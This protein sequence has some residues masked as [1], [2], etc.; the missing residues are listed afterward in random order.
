MVIAAFWGIIAGSALLIGAVTGIYSKIS[1]R[2]TGLIM[3]FGTGALIAAASFELLSEALKESSI[4]NVALFFI[5]GALIFTIGDFAV[6][7]FGG[8]ERKRSKEG[9]SGSQGLAIFF[10]TILDAIPES[11]IIGALIAKDASMNIVLISSI[12]ISNFP[13]G[14]SSSIGLKKG[15]FSDKKIL[16]LWSSVILLSAIFSI[17]G[18]LVMDKVSDNIFAGLSAFAAGAI[19]AM[20]SSTMMP[21]AF[22]EGGPAVGLFASLGLLTA[23]IL[24][25]L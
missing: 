15:K 25:T 19:I 8:K 13:E 16:T 4:F 17:V 23:L 18:Y 12:F 21:E 22:E 6:I 9:N 5:L 2:L 3:A 20:V 11:V 24:T 14:L 1:K 7:K 10:G